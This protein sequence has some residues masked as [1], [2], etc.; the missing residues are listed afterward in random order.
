MSMGLCTMQSPMLTDDQF[1]VDVWWHESAIA[2]GE[3]SIGCIGVSLIEGLADSGIIVKS[4]VDDTCLLAK[5]CAKAIRDAA[6]RV[7][8]SEIPVR[9]PGQDRQA[10]EVRCQEIAI[11]RR[12]IAQIDRYWPCIVENSQLGIVAKDV[13]SEKW[14]KGSDT[15][16]PRTVS[17]N[18]DLLGTGE[19]VSG[20]IHAGTLVAQPAV[21]AY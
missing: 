18:G 12:R 2:L 6:L 16:A 10:G 7:E 17:H 14:S 19:H 15:D 21:E 13:A 11:W 20:N 9:C 1:P 8:F 3:E 5:G 4:P